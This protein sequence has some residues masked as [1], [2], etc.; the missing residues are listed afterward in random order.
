[1]RVVVI[2]GS[3]R[4]KGNTS[5]IT[6]R[7]TRRLNELGAACEVVEIGT[8]AIRGCQGCD[9][10]FRSKNRRCRFAD[11]IVNPAL[12][13][14]AE[15]DAIVLGSPVYFSGIAG[16]MK[17]FLDR[18]FYVADANG[19][20]FRRKVGAA[21]VVVHRSGGSSALDGLNHYLTYSEM[22]IASSNYWNIAHGTDPGDVMDDHEGIRIIETLVDNIAMLLRSPSCRSPD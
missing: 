13:K 21:F 5:F 10:C 16:Q 1:M 15:A 7:V 2:N 18:A 9:A 14:M 11:D 6:S 19:G 3:P 12:E 22:I 17:A 8:G 4:Q 20:L